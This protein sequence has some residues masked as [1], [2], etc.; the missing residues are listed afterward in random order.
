M[1][2]A[3]SVPTVTPHGGC[4]PTETLR[5]DP[6]DRLELECSSMCNAA[7]TVDEFEWLH[8][9]MG[10]EA[11]IVL[12]ESRESKLVIESVDYKDGGTY[13]CRC[14]PEGQFCEQK[15]YSKLHPKAPFQIYT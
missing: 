13:K 2:S 1:V 14:L 5:L 6:D 10:K 8:G 9:N 15:V 12:M 11:D 7:N 3:L 4:K